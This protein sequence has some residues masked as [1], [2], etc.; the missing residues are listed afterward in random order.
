[1]KNKFSTR[2]YEPELLDAPDI[3]KEMLFQNLSE[4]DLINSRLGGHNATISGI[5]KLITDKHKTYHIVDIGCGGGDAILR[6]DRWARKNNFKVRFTGVDMN[7]DCIEY[8]KKYCAE[9]KDLKASVMDYRDFLKSNSDID[10]IHCSL[11]CHHLTDEQLSELFT[12]MRDHAR[13]G[14]VINDLHRHWLAYYSIWFLTRIFN[15]SKLVKNDAPLSVRRGFS[16]DELRSFLSSAGLQEA[17]LSWQWA[18]RFL[19]NYSKN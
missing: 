12:F 18:F 11:F 8:M 13:T 17:E 9:V 3:P 14:F 16:R 4:L 6:I 19:I 2:S 7:S 10:I 1:M 5:K 15:G